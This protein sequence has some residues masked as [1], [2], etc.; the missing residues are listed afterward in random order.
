MKNNSH[1]LPV[2]FLAFA[3][4]HQSYLYKLTEEQDGIRSALKAAEDANLCEVVYETDCDID[5]I[6]RVFD[7]YQDRI[8][9]FHYGGHAEDY[10]LLLKAASGKRQYARSEGLVSFLAAQK[11]LQ[12]VFINGCS[13]QTQ[14]EM[15]RD[16][17]I[18]AVIAT[19][20]PID[21][22]AA[23]VISTQF[24]RGLAAGRTI[25]QAWKMAAAR[26]KTEKDSGAGFRAGGSFNK[27]K[28]E[29]HISFPWALYIRPGA[30]PV[31]EWNLPRASRNPLF[32]LP[33]PNSYYR[34]LPPAPFPGLHYFQQQDAAIFFG[35][36]AQIREL[37]NHI[38]GLHPVTLFY[39]KSGVG[40]S[41]LLYAGLLPRIE[42]KYSVIY[43]RRDQE[44]G[45]A[46]TLMRALNAQEEM[47]AAPQEF[48]QQRDETLQV[49]NELKAKIKEKHVAEEI[50]NLIH[51]LPRIP[52]E[53][54]VE[55]PDVLK[56]WQAI[57]NE[58][59]KPLIVI[60]DQV[61][62]KF[63]RPM[64]PDDA[65]ADELIT[66]LNTIR[67]LFADSSTGIRGKL[68]LSYRKEFHPEIR[69]TFQ[70]LSLPYAE[71]FLKRLDREGIMEAVD[72]ITREGH[73][74][75]KYRLV[76]ESTPDNN[77]PAMIADDLLEDSESPIAPVLQII[78]KKLW[79]SATA[80]NEDQ[81]R[82]TVAQY[83]QHK[84]AGITM[85]EFF[86]Q[87]MTALAQIVPQA[88]SSGLALDLLNAHTTDMGTAGRCL[89]T[90]LETR[91]PDRQT[92][93][94]Q[95]LQA[96]MDL[97][98][99]L[100]IQP[101]DTIL[102]HDTLAPV[103]IREYNGSDKP[104]QRA[105]R[106]LNGKMGDFLTNESDVWLDEADL[107]V[108]EAGSSGMRGLAPAESE[109]LE[110]S[111]QKKNRREKIRKGIWAGGIAMLALI[112][113]AAAI[114]FFALGEAQEQTSIA[115]RQAAMADSSAREAQISDSLAQISAFEAKKSDSLA[116]IRATEA[117]ESDSLTQIALGQATRQKSRAERQ[118]I[119][120]RSQFLS[121][122]A[123]ELANEDNTAALHLVAYAYGL[124]ADD[125]PTSVSQTLSKIYENR[126][127]ASFYKQKLQHDSWVKSAQF[128]PDGK[129]IL[130]RSKS[131]Y[132]Y[133]AEEARVWD[134]Y[135]GELLYTI[136]NILSAVYSPDG[137]FI[138]THAS[139]EADDNNISL[140]DASSGK[141]RWRIPNSER[142]RG[143]RFS[144]DGEKILAFYDSDS[145]PYLQVRSIN[146]D[147]LTTIE[148][149]SRP[150]FSPDS[151]MLLTNILQV[152]NRSGNDVQLSTVSGKI[153]ATFK[154]PSSVHFHRFSPDAQTILT[155][156][157]VSKDNTTETH[158]QL[159]SLN[160]EVLDTLKYPSFL[161][162]ATFSAD[163]KAIFTSWNDKT[164]Q[165]WLP[166]TDEK[167]KKILSHDEDISSITLSPD[168]EK[169]LCWTRNGVL[170][171]SDIRLT[172]AQ[173]PPRILA[174]DGHVRSL[175]FSKD[176]RLV[177]TS[178][179]DNTARLWETE[180]G[181]LLNIFTH[182]DDDDGEVYTAVFSPDG[183]H[184][185]TA[186]EDG[187]ARIWPIYGLF[188]K[189]PLSGGK[190][191]GTK[192][193]QG[194]YIWPGS[195]FT[196]AAF[197]PDG[198]RFVTGSAYGYSRIW[199]AQS[200]QETHHLTS[201]TIHS[202][203]T[204]LRKSPVDVAAFSP[205]GQRI[206]TVSETVR[207]WSLEG[208][209]LGILPHKDPVYI[210]LFSPDGQHILTTT[211]SKA[212]LWHNDRATVDT[213][214]H[215]YIGTA[216]FSPDS[217]Q[218]VTTSASSENSIVWDVASGDALFPANLLAGDRGSDIFSPDG[219]QLLTIS[220]DDSLIIWNMA[221][222]N[223]IS[224][225]A[226][227]DV[228]AARFS[229]DGQ[230]L[231]IACDNDTSF[232]WSP[233]NGVQQIFVHEKDVR[234]VAFSPDGQFILTAS[235]DEQAHLWSLNG[236]KLTVFPEEEI[237]D[238]QEVW[239]RFSPDGK[240]VLTKKG[241]WSLSGEI[242]AAF[243]L[244]EDRP[245]FSADGTKLISL[246]KGESAS[247][248]LPPAGVYQW[249]QTAPVY[250]LSDAEKKA[251]GIV[252]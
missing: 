126:D 143:T 92:L 210:A 5:K 84:K 167:L 58:E 223:I 228:F 28:S 2:I 61:E 104:G 142:P 49:L 189:L 159:W 10:S 4:D 46:G 95:L 99:L 74:Q 188:Q 176:G 119:R 215:R 146:G 97:S 247:L 164:V 185:L 133:F 25:D 153:L 38:S 121:I 123:R 80:A 62:E 243:P 44:L 79:D 203:G 206:L 201:P 165:Q 17:G 135:S 51:S 107:A 186:S 117:Q 239:T 88:E 115:E 170:L 34:D 67:P 19:S 221:N 197:S 200:G 238:D 125:P 169:M 249:L 18:P 110:I 250:R 91:Y 227:D 232:L 209:S 147:S 152:P 191:A 162:S 216:N 154:H 42:D 35:R 211:G 120:A 55:L 151:K 36:G 229:P 109:L 16:K 86:E 195:D 116:Q 39:G 242:V 48:A 12:L 184:V 173:T 241:L 24:Y 64:P 138:L 54:S 112:L 244:H 89:R 11:G 155:C 30:E 217:R 3:N 6:F 202:Q 208:D 207:L 122:R 136:E 57:E 83:Q 43:L 180:K 78:L 214:K 131:D 177:L 240:F 113:I 174:H 172:L 98:L 127:Q 144:P 32:G 114:A 224:T 187:S 226:H 192:Q 7:Q 94:D 22:A 196:A 100:R 134:R 68:I 183:Q 237:D 222:G 9:V 52:M 8:A 75:R 218:L 105:A 65:A 251:Y 27:K 148:D 160:G 171:R 139:S 69:D 102:A 141:A 156:Y 15:L 101:D 231:I 157:S 40:K 73:T 145:L 72:G 166:M 225:F 248:H 130:T 103:V 204:F 106:L 77:L 71:V 132:G 245:I 128:S 111:R 66:F 37:F 230:Q 178:A 213:L 118:A 234:A 129:R 219:R 233:V 193:F 41:S 81:P 50:E 252:E 82:F 63:T 163:G 140:W 175:S 21:D 137:Q 13:S 23:T 194:R 150:I 70:A 56:R 93:V 182:N 235:A 47:K 87:Q 31:K 60:L 76:V 45:L 181:K 149:A 124:V 236:Q 33:L 96:C 179:D 14:A 1:P 168:G 212:F 90:E 190:F 20:Q 29:A 108:V 205:D 199:D 53:A 85:G 158:L 161:R 59:S 246:S 26:V 198:Q 220:P